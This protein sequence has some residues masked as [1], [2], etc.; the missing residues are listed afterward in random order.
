MSPRGSAMVKKECCR[1]CGH[2]ISS[3]AA[4]SLWCRLR[5]IKIHSHIAPFVFCHHWTQQS[6]SLPKIDNKQFDLDKQLDFERS[7]VSRD[8]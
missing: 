1:S 7:L 6:P 5:K 8:L 4:S 2:C 3:A